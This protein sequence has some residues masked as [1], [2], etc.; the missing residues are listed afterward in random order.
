[1]KLFGSDAS[2]DW[3]VIGIYSKPN[4]DTI[5]NSIYVEKGKIYE[6]DIKVDLNHLPPQP[7]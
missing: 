3:R 7:F 2:S 4:N 1:V 5:P 6:A